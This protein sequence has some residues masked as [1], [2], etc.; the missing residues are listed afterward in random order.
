MSILRSSFFRKTSCS[1]SKTIL[2][3]SGGGHAVSGPTKA[4]MVPT[5]QA[6]PAWLKISLP[7][8]CPSRNRKPSQTC[9]STESKAMPPPPPETEGES[10]PLLTPEDAGPARQQRAVIN[11]DSSKYRCRCGFL[12][13]IG[14]G[15]TTRNSHRLRSSGKRRVTQRRPCLSSP[16]REPR[17]GRDDHEGF[18]GAN[19]VSSPWSN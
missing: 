11:Y 17:I 18:R 9:T 14:P 8:H 19:A 13:P 10:L 16:C 7:Q 5:R 2:S 3:L 15:M 6:A 1:R 4:I 12:V